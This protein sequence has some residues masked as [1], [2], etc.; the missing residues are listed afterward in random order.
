ML[1][2]YFDPR[3]RKWREAT[4]DCIMRSII[5]LYTSQH[6]VRAITSKRVRWAGD[7]ARKER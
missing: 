1:R 7:V 2:K 5:N 4:E 6:I 3:G